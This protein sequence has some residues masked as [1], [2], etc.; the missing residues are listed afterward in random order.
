[1]SSPRSAGYR[2]VFAVP[3]FRAVFAAHVLSMLGEVLGEIALSV[4]V[5]RLTGSP[6]LSALSLALG[7]L[8]YALG[9][10]L[11]SGVADRFPTRRVLVGCDLVCAT[12]AAGLVVPGMP[13]GAL[14]ALRCVLAAVAPV[15]TGTRAATLTDILGT[16]DR[17]VLGRSVIRLVSQSAQ[18]A[19]FG[20]GGLLLLAV[21]PHG[22]LAVTTVT[23]LASA[24]VLRLGT[25]TRP[26]RA[27]AGRLLGDS[28]AATRRLLADRRIRSLL[29]FAWVPP[30]FVVV[31]EALLT[32]LVAGA[33]GSPAW[34]GLLM[35]GM[36]IGAVLGETLAGALLGPRGR[37]RLM[38][39]AA[40]W[41]A[42]PSLA[43][44]FGPPLWV[45]LGCQLATGLAIT[46]SL[47]LDQRFLA[48]VP[49]SLRGSALTL[50]TAGQMTA[51]GLA[52][53]AAGAAAD[54]L[55]VPTVI[56]AGGVLGVLL[57][58]FVLWQVRLADRAGA[59]PRVPLAGHA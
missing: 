42:V 3:E 34:L 6:L 16:G 37:A 5:Y 25:R 21:S 15:F 24:T 55:P 7:L 46:Y 50:L 38:A 52:M 49:E 33:H 14:L 17:Y 1:M 20:I 54:V 29:I 12:A 18:L 11:L 44:A 9:G 13:V 39:P 43:Y 53:T 48:A 28:L 30:M 23:F 47:G 51:Q 2:S 45:C 56:A 10:I 40:L 19:G 4:L 32:P 22:V 27:A 41:A 57:L 26:A 35:C 36:P 59:D 58:P 8:P 31:G